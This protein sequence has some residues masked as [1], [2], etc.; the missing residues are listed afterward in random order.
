MAKAAKDVTEPKV[1]IRKMNHRIN[2]LIWVTNKTCPI[3]SNI[4]VNSHVL[5]GTWCPL[6]SI[7]GIRVKDG[8]PTSIKVACGSG[9]THDVTVVTKEEY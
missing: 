9:T 4:H 8:K 1:T 2:G 7:F 3:A 5:C 6:C